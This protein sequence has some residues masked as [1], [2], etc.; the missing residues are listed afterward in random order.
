MYGLVQS[1]GTSRLRR[2][3]GPSKPGLV[4]ESGFDTD[5]VG[6]VPSTA[7]VLG[8]CARRRGR[9]RVSTRQTPE[10]K[11]STVAELCAPV[12]LKN[13]PSIGPLIPSRTRL[14]KIGFGPHRVPT[15]VEG[16]SKR[17]R[18]LSRGLVYTITSTPPS[19]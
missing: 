2:R 3:R 7:V 1:I 17:S 14:T 10:D 13:T 19:W 6:E 16:R 9:R 18:R 4:S 12:G 15:K 5:T 8:T 11:R